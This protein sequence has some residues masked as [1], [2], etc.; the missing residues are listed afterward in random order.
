MDLH[1][2]VESFTGE[3]AESYDAGRGQYPP[4]V[5]EAI[6]LAPASRVLDLGAGTGLLSEALLAAG[7]DVVAVEPMADMRA[8]LGAKNGRSRALDGTAEA[9]PL[10]AASVD[11]ATAADAFHWFAPDPAA[12]ELARVIRP[13]GLL[14]LSWR[15]PEPGPGTEW[16]AQIFALVGGHIGDHPGFT[17]DQGRDGITRS[18]HFTPFERR[19]AR[20]TQ[21]TD[22]DGFLTGLRSFSFVAKMGETER[23]EL[24]EEVRAH[25]PSGPLEVPVLAEVWVATRL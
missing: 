17:P 20:F 24:V 7:H 11:A 23:E 19:E 14:A 22:T 16:I 13:G 10:P 18:G 2:Y 3:V 6:G 12:A 1:P 4:G 9:I 15:R 8:V 5:I 25:V 21:R